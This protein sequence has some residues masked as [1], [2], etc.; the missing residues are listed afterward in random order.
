MAN[1]FERM[2]KEA[3]VVEYEAVP[4]DLPE[5][6]EGKEKRNL[7]HDNRC[8]SQDSNLAPQEYKS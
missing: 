7:S 5:E 8:L 3:A 4:T 1:G 2:P 6:T